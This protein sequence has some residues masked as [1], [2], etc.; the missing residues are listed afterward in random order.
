MTTVY[1]DKVS[2][3]NIFA[4]MKE[5]WPVVKLYSVSLDFV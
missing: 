4:E 3:S 1:P 2:F 5:K